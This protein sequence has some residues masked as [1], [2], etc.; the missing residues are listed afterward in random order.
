MDI[1]TLR[2]VLTVAAFAA[3]LGV[4]WW[5][6]GPSRKARFEQDA[7]LVF[8]DDEDRKELRS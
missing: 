8:N 3:Y 4:V 5:A 1:N 2:T 7:Q 6:F